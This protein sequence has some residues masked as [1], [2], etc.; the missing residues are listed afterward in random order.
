MAFHLGC[1]RA[2]NESGLLDR[3]SVLSSVSGGSVLASLYCCRQESFSEFERRARE[4][5]KGGLEGRIFRAAASLTGVRAIASVFLSLILAVPFSA[6][7]LVATALAPTWSKKARVRKWLRFKG[8]RKTTRTDL[9]EIALRN[10][11]VLGAVLLDQLPRS[12][13][14]LIINAADLPLQTAFRFTRNRIG[15]WPTGAVVWPGCRLSEAVAA[16]AAYP[17]LLPAIDRELVLAED[18]SRT[19]RFLLTDGG[20]YDNLGV[21]VFDPTRPAKYSFGGEKVDFI[22]ACIAEPGLP[23]GNDRPIFWPDRMRAA[24]AS[25]H[26]QLHRSTMSNLHQWKDAGRIRG[27]IM[28]YLGQDDTKL[29][30]GE[31]QPIQPLGNLRDYP[32]D[33]APMPDDAA[34]QLIARGETQTRRLVSLY[35]TTEIL[36]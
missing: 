22:I 2:L 27:F 13:P 14:E 10:K 18:G 12:L 1:M 6:L 11:D 8:R 9:L 16:S 30:E 36:S 15:T 31:G 24:F 5:L 26:R 21:D 33:F 25:V 29:P 23:E 20:V 28:P 19:V 34:D 4:L 17:I 3:I 35:L 7:R 32:V